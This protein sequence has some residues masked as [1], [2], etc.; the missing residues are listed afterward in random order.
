[1]TD[2]A[3]EPRHPGVNLGPRHGAAHDAAEVEVFGFWVFMMSDAVLFGLLFATYVTMR[4]A[5]GNGPALSSLYDLRP[6][7]AETLV[8][9]ASSFTFGM[10]SLSMK[11]DERPTGLRIWLAITLLLGVVFLVLEGHDFA[12]MID[13]G[14]VPQAG[15]ALSA[16]W[17]L[18][19]LHGLHVSLASIWLISILAQTR[20]HG[21]DDAL[22]VAV[23]RLAVLWHFLDI[24]WI[25]IFTVVYIGA[26]A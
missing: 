11:Y 25:G 1:M 7:L 13:K 14:G 16:F 12:A 2:A 22:K 26:Y 21:V 15:G 9:L 19:P 24:V 5:T 23:L 4:N 8:L 6:V 20:I 17:A 10:A 3:S 18:V